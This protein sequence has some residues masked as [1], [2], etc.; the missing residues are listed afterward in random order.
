MGIIR[1]PPLVSHTLHGLF[2]YTKKMYNL[3]LL[4]NS[5]VK[6]AERAYQTLTT[7]ILPAES[8]EDVQAIIHDNPDLTLSVVH[9]QEFF[10]LI[11]PKTELYHVRSLLKKANIKQVKG[12]R[13][14]IDWIL[15]YRL[16]IINEESGISPQEYRII[17]NTNRVPESLQSGCSIYPDTHGFLLVL[18]ANDSVG[19]ETKPLP[20][21]SEARV[22]VGRDSSVSMIR[23]GRSCQESSRPPP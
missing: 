21:G 3:A 4:G 17:R 11:L 20:L 5:V 19:F 7:I 6:W 1:Q 23:T 16:P 18:R 9:L 10:A 14:L 8:Q 2:D 22:V 12:N 13:S 15:L